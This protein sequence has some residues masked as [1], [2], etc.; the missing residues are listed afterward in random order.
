MLSIICVYNNNEKLTECLLKS[1]EGQDATYDL[2]LVDNT[3]NRFPNASSALNHGATTATGDFFVFAHQDVEFYSRSWVRDV[4]EFLLGLEPFGWAGVAGVNEQ[5][6]LHGFVKNSSSLLWTQ[7]GLSVEIQTLDEVILICK[8]REHETYFDEGVPGWHA[9]GVDACVTTS[10]Q[11]LKNYV[12]SFPLWHNS[13]RSNNKGL[14]ISHNYVREKFHGKL[15]VIHTSCGTISTTSSVTSGVAQKIRDIDDRVFRRLRIKSRKNGFWDVMSEMTHDCETIAC[16][17]DYFPHECI[18]AE[19]FTQF[20][21]GR[22]AQQITHCFSGDDFE[23]TPYD[24]IIFETNLAPK[25][26][27]K[28]DLINSILPNTRIVVCT[29]ERDHKAVLEKLATHYI[30]KTRK[31]V[32]AATGGIGESVYISLLSPLSS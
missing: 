14:D 9:Y 24:C 7:Y 17:Y 21:N 31:T 22:S 32:R 1:L 28:I 30:I 26:A 6:Q 15:D 25:I 18:T 19:S 13:N 4:E 20:P 3:N 27:D 16:Y 8:R 29:D 12:V 10:L 2:V 11:G 5:G 23:E